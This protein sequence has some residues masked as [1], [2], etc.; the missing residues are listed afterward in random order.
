MRTGFALIVLG[1]VI[2]AGGAMLAA[3]GQ[4]RPGVIGQAR[5]FVENRGRADAV[6]VVLQE[7]MTPSPISVQVAGTPTV[8]LSPASV[9]QARLARQQWEYR[10]VD[11]EREQDPAAALSR[12]GA[13]GWEATGIQLLNRAGAPVVMKRPR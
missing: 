7:V 5:V 8:A 11:L 3:P 10:T 2:T 9:V 4:D 6:P 12:A 1:G 13:E